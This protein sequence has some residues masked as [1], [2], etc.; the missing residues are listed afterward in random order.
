MNN[1]LKERNWFNV[2]KPLGHIHSYEA[3]TTL[4]FQGEPV[5]HVGIIIS[6]MAS[7]RAVSK[8]G[9]ETWVNS[10]YPG[11]FFGHVSLIS[12]SPIAF[13]IQAYRH[14]QALMI[15]VKKLQDLLRENQELSLALSQDLA[16]RLNLMTARLIEAVNVSSPGR[17]C[18]ELLRLSKPIGVEPDKLIVRPAPVFVDLALRIS[19]TRETVSRTVNRLQKDGVL[20]REPG[21]LIINDLMA[22][23]AKIK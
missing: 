3:E 4:L 15:P 16:R 14:V 6:G 2:L 22:L 8:D 18:A 5:P 11:D 17:V 20:S 23:E 21:A 12:Q 1:H 19:A 13:E 10:F 9:K 7:G